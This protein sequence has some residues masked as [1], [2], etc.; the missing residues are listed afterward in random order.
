VNEER[1]SALESDLGE[2]LDFLRR[3]WALDHALQLRSRKL[4]RRLGITGPQRLALRLVGRFPGLL[5]GT[6]AR[7]L[8]LHPSTVTGIVNRLE[9]QDLLQRQTDAADRRRQ[10][11]M[12]TAR[13]A[14]LLQSKREETIEQATG[15]AMSALSKADIEAAARVL[16]SLRSHLLNPT[17]DRNRD[18]RRR[19]A[20]PPRP[21]SQRKRGV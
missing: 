8:H 16:S 18:G 17:E 9:K 3:L 13:G 12:I 14:A 19:A 2:V 20:A 10:R 4:A 5:A 1:E 6:L 15:R 11:L 21:A 7:L